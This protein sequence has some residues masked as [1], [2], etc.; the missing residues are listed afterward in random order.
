MRRSWIWGVFA[1]LTVALLSSTGLTPVVS[2]GTST[3]ASGSALPRT[4]SVAVNAASPDPALRAIADA[5]PQV[6]S[7]L[8][9]LPSDDLA[10]AE[11]SY[12]EALRGNLKPTEAQAAADGISVSAAAS[13]AFGA[14]AVVCAIGIA[15]DIATV[16]L[17]CL[18]A[19]AVA[20]VVV[21][22]VYLFD[23]W[24]STPLKNLGG[25][26][27]KSS[28]LYAP[29]VQQ[30]RAVMGG[31]AN[32]F[33]NG[34]QS[35]NV[36]SQ[37][38]MTLLNGTEGLLEY[39][40]AS[41][42]LSQ[43]GNTTFNPLL[44]LQQSGIAQTSQSYIYGQEYEAA[45]D[46]ATVL[47][48]TN[49]LYGYNSG[50]GGDGLVCELETGTV[51]S[52][53]IN[54]SFGIVWG[55]GVRVPLNVSGG[56]YGAS[57]SKDAGVCLEGATVSS[58]S[59]I[60]SQVYPGTMIPNEIE[61]DA[62]YLG[63]N[64][65]AID[66]SPYPGYTGVGVQIEN[67]V[68]GKL[69][70]VTINTQVKRTATVLTSVPQGVYKLT[71]VPY[72]CNVN[73]LA[74]D[75]CDHPTG[76]YTALPLNGG[77]I[78]GGG[79]VPV[80]WNTSGTG[81][82]SSYWS[83][84]ATDTPMIAEMGG[85]TV[86]GTNGLAW[87]CGYGYT[88]QP[89]VSVNGLSSGSDHSQIEGVLE[90]AGDGHFRVYQMCPAGDSHFEW[91]LNELE[92]ISTNVAK[93]YWHFLRSQGWTKAS[94][95]PP[96]CVIPSIASMLPPNYSVSALNGLTASQLQALYVAYITELSTDFSS[97]LTTS[98][99]CGTHVPTPTNVT[100]SNS[101][102]FAIGNVYIPPPHKISKDTQVLAEPSTWNITNV[103][104]MIAPSTGTLTIPV[105]LTKVWEAP[106]SN[107]SVIYYGPLVGPAN[108]TTPYK[109][110]NSNAGQAAFFIEGLF[111]HFSGNS[112]SPYGSVYP[113]KT[114]NALGNGDA[115]SI[116]A[117]WSY[118]TTKNYWQNLSTCSI[119][120]NKL[121]YKISGDSCLTPG[122]CSGG[123]GFILG[124]DACDF[125]FISAIDQGLNTYIPEPWACV[126][127]Y[128]IVI[129][130]VLVVIY[131][132]VKIAE[133]AGRRRRMS[134]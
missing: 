33:T 127:T 3:V 103:Y 5:D 81:P 104:L 74:S 98:T 65:T 116:S 14:A 84:L 107:P 88:S 36:S 133:G 76:S 126:V 79:W 26:G 131:A 70:N 130:I 51:V 59:Q 30:F 41:A 62:F 37:N 77:F 82:L 83:E 1:V 86:G 10:K 52:G 28:V 44:D 99:F 73:N 47:N 92:Y 94:E 23:S 100:V 45:N 2:L 31:I 69:Y 113:A 53:G 6:A 64:A 39:E 125:I 97:G 110:N 49:G 75:P 124:S 17:S 111:T 60:V 95:V 24:C 38:T 102:L 114:N 121:K 108:S 57:P 56:S 13:V 8:R 118:N 109:I 32:F 7:L 132:I 16:G 54:G 115:I 105:G 71:M 46:V 43:L 50:Y 21:L 80:G 78:S 123:G 20:A 96:T 29:A 89:G 87:A 61:H 11:T 12:V 72:V 122:Q 18:A 9:L 22:V 58:N 134:G 112:T 63:D 42:A 129:G 35:L 90:S 106:A 101:N 66:S 25:C 15:A 93:A 91:D 68:T 40:A 19:F 27:S 67:V 128:L 4:A 55:G 120:I 119:A 85:S 34:T 117:C 48:S